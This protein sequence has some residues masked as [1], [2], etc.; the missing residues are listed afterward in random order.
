M[1]LAVQPLT[2]QDIPRLVEISFLSLSQSGFFRSVGKIPNPDSI[3]F[4]DLLSPSERKDIQ[5]AHL[6]ETWGKDP[7]LKILKAVDVETGEMVAF[8]M[9]H[10]FKGREGLEIWQKMVGSG[11]L[12]RSVPKGILGREREVRGWAFCWGKLNVVRRELFGPSGREHCRKLNINLPRII[13]P[14]F[15]TSSAVK[16][17]LT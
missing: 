14:T 15:T 7:T 12:E 2:L 1:P 17:S 11:E 3:A 4:I 5:I 16:F 10:I 6:T 8:A 9:W 13:T